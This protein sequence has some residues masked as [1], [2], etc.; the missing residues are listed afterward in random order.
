MYRETVKSIILFTLV[1]SSAILTY[2][3]WSYQP[4]FSQIDTS[5]EST[6]N[7]GQG[8]PLPFESVMRAYQLIWV[9]GEEARG[10]IDEDAVVGVR[11]FLDGTRITDIN[12][13]NNMNRLD[14]TVKEDGSEEFLIVDYPSEMPAKSL[15]QIL[16]FEYEET[17]PDYKF[18]RI[19]V[20]I[21]SPQVTFFMLNEAL[22][23]VA[24]AQTDM[25][26]DYLL[27]IVNDYEDSFEDY[28]GLITNQQTANNKTAI[29]GPDAPGEVSVMSFLSAQISIDTINDILFMEDEVS[30]SQNENVY[31]YEAENG[32][33]TY[34]TDTYNYVYTNLNESLSSERDPHQTIQRSFNFLNSHIGLAPEHILFDYEEEGNQ[35]I[36]RYTLNGYAVFSDEIAMTISTKYGSNALFEYE[37]PLLY[38]NAQVPSEETEKLARIEDV[39]YE[40]ALNE[41]LDLQKVSKITIGYN[42]RFSEEQTELNLV[43]FTPEWYVKY[44]GEWLRYNEGGLQ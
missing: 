22:D 3:V 13:Y 24:V 36:Y 37:R 28:T 25:E 18:D 29:Y 32:L 40:I 5:I 1:V 11:E 30:V 34:N 21:A 38:I 39:R 27:S 16:G 2:M 42:L 19:V 6:S 9:N 14:P 12:V 35:S 17:L 7:T 10:T 33:A 8:E 15:F 4:E 26:S 20:D 31:V 44:D 23:R 43:N 41:A